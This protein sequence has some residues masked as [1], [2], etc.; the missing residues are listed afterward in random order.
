MG[1]WYLMYK[2]LYNG[3]NT[4]CDAGR[5]IGTG[6]WFSTTFKNS[7]S[8]CLRVPLKTMFLKYA[9]V[10]HH[11]NTDKSTYSEGSAPVLVLHPEQ[12]VSVPFTHQHNSS[13]I[14]TIMSWSCR[15]THKTQTNVQPSLIHNHS[16]FQKW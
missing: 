7:P 14:S 12:H 3:R 4:N 11:K 10:L 2:L 13:L 5:S 6:G 15:F 16:N 9:S 1:K 8:C